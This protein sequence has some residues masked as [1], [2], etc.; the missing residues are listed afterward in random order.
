MNFF[1]FICEFEYNLHINIFIKK[2]QTKNL[3]IYISFFLFLKQLHGMLNLE[4]LNQEQKFPHK[5]KSPLNLQQGS[6]SLRNYIPTNLN[7]TSNEDQIIYF[8]GKNNIDQ[9]FYQIGET[10]QNF[11]QTGHVEIQQE[12]QKDQVLDITQ[13]FGMQK[14]MKTSKSV[15]FIPPSWQSLDSKKKS[16]QFDQKDTPIYRYDHTIKFEVCDISKCQKIIFY[17]FST[18]FYYFIL[19]H[20]LQ[21]DSIWDIY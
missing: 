11:Y 13:K 5:I 10:N 17:I 2:L 20:L 16:D 14:Q 4:K 9:K 1:I 3:F 15:D 12:I 6:K 18:I 8:Q 21:S 7:S 19:F